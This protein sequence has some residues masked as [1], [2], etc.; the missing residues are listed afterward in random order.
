MPVGHGGACDRYVPGE[1]AVPVIKR[2]GL[3]T[4][5]PNAV[6]PFCGMSATGRSTKMKVSPPMGTTAAASS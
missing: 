3:L 4:Q 5:N 2:E 6:Y 1:Q